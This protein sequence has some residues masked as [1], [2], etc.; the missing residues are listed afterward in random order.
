MQHADAVTILKGNHEVELLQYYR[1]GHNQA[2]MDKGGRATLDDFARGGL[3]LTEVADWMAGFPL[4]Y[5]TNELFVSH[6]GLGYAAHPFD[7][8]AADGVVWNREPLKRLPQ[9]QVH[10]HRPLRQY[11]AAYTP[12]THSWNVDTGAYYGYGL[13]AL[14]LADDAS[15]LEVL[16]VPT[17]S[18]DID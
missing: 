1:D 8:D 13:S 6:A 18:R 3:S 12:A 7:A 2:W 11:E 16:Q 17:V 9:L 14:R 10:G 15:V 4:V 5:Q